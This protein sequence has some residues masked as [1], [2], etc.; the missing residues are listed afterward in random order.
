MQILNVLS[1]L[2]GNKAQVPALAPAPIVP[3]HVSSPV[4]IYPPGFSDFVRRHAPCPENPNIPLDPVLILLAISRGGG[5]RYHMTFVNQALDMPEVQEY[6]DNPWG[7]LDYDPGMLL[8]SVLSHAVVR[9]D[10]DTVRRLLDMGVYPQSN[11]QEP[12]SDA[13]FVSMIGSIPATF[14]RKEDIWTSKEPTSE[15]AKQI[16][17][18]VF[19]SA[20]DNWKENRLGF[21]QSLDGLKA[22]S[23]DTVSVW[24]TQRIDT[25]S[26]HAGM[27][28]AA[29][30]GILEVLKEIDPEIHRFKDH[31]HV[32]LERLKPS[33]GAPDAPAA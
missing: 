27:L 2:F 8:Q 3:E 25:A 20:R 31:L 1:R 6:I 17:K 11:T 5:E 13:L 26:H 30:P 23:G 32:L 16:F 12:I 22:I 7:I 21:I 18:M 33:V 10:I 14:K 19:E 28:S 15:A 9:E 29:R 24:G 4:D